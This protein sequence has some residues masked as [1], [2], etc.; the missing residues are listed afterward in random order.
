MLTGCGFEFGLSFL[1]ERVVLSCLDC[2]IVCHQPCIR[3]VFQIRKVSRKSDTHSFVPFEQSC[4]LPRQTPLVLL[5]L[6]HPN[7]F[8]RTTIAAPQ[9]T[10]RIL[11]SSQILQALTLYNPLFP[12][13]ATH[14]RLPIQRKPR[15]LLPRLVRRLLV[16]EADERLAAHTEVM[17]GDDGCDG[18]VGFEEIEEGFFEVCGG[19]EGRGCGEEQTESNSVGLH[20][21][22]FSSPLKL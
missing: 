8:S 7:Y 20:N 11:I 13:P 5:L 6:L 17:V 14:H 16:R 22:H 4:V 12:S 3:R 9:Q 10:P 19:V 2:I 1:A 18:F 21:R 15:N